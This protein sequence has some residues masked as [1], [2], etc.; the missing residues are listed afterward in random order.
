MRQKIAQ[1]FNG[2]EKTCKSVAALR[3]FRR[4]G[5]RHNL[6]FVMKH[7]V[8]EPLEV[9]ILL[10]DELLDWQTSIGAPIPKI[11]NGERMRYDFSW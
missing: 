10:L 5:I 1:P 7:Q 4:R 3:R 11:P 6:S 8:L 9:S 2:I